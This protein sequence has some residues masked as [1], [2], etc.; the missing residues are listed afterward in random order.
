LLYSL[1]RA[2]SEQHINTLISTVVI[3]NH[4]PFKENFD[5]RTDSS[6]SVFG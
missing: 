4:P 6:S 1:S 3:T 2:M 5:S